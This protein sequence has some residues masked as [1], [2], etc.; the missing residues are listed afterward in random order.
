[1]GGL[2][3]D[4]TERVNQKESVERAAKAKSEFLSNMS[5]EL[6][7]PM[8][9]ILSYSDMGLIVQAE[10][11]TEAAKEYLGNIKIAGSRLL[12][13]LNDLLDLAKMES[14][15]MPLN[16]TPCDFREVI[17]SARC[18]LKPLLERK[19]ISLTTDITAKNTKSVFDKQ[20]IIQVLINLISNSIKFSSD[21]GEIRVTL[22]EDRST[23]DPDVLRCSVGDEGPGIPAAELE[24]VFD[25]FIQS[26]KTKSGAGGTGLGLSIC[27]EI[28][29]AHGGQIWAENR[30]P[31]GALFS[32]TIP[33]GL[34]AG[35][36]VDSRMAA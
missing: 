15:R 2:I 3:Q 32:F 34:G 9:A 6:R 5:H 33:R 20:R 27:R 35:S 18:E 28:L 29:K 36:R 12:G 4:I 16:R 30:H 22:S 24:A 31:K 25:K 19:N 11:Q 14:G 21:G 8:H 1:M 26:S 10:S 17:E 13:L 7:T 23:G